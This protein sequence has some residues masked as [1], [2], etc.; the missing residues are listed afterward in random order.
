M[1][2][3]VASRFK[4][5]QDSSVL[6]KAERFA[7]F[8][9]PSLMAKRVQGTA[10]VFEGD[11]Q[12]VGALLVNNLT[13]KLGTALFP[14][15]RPFFKVTLSE[16]LLRQA[17]TDVASIRTGAAELE[18][19]STVQLFKNASL[20]KLHRAIS[21]AIVTGNF[22][23]YRDQVKQRFLVWNLNSYTVK[24]N[25]YGDVDEIILKQDMK[26]KDLE[27]KLQQEYLAKHFQKKPDDNVEYY[28]EIVYDRTGDVPIAF[29]AQSVDD[30]SVGDVAEYPEHICPYVAVAWNLAQGEHY[31]RGYVEDYSSD[32]HYL[33]VLSE[34]LA[35]YE[36]ESLSMLNLVDEAAGGVIDDYS[37]A[38]TGQFVPGKVGSITTYDRGDYNKIG[39][40]SA[41]LEEVK[42]RL[43]RAFMYTGHQRDAERVT[44]EE[45]RTLAQE[46]ENLLG[47]AYSVLA[48]GLQAPL[49]YLCMYEVA[50]E[51]DIA[52]LTYGVLSRNYHPE[53]LTGI[54]ALTQAAETQNLIRATQELV[55][56][57]PALMEFTNRF[58]NDK[59]IEMVFANNA[60][61]IESISKTPEQLEQEAEAEQQ[62][63]EA[64]TAAIAAGIE[65]GAMQ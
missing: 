25:A 57:I 59:I 10:Q 16:E 1:K 12:S 4:K 36:I 42:Q 45:V 9:L 33:S 40:I 65:D 34:E 18:R 43:S 24:R 37:E 20:A 3:D 27:P 22:L 64:E 52:A 47:G 55:Q 44:A 19:L 26:F 6:R 48:E 28:T 53:I 29:I 17:G 14:A 23:L 21:L 11:F 61:P 38:T 46:A 56:I 58:D 15:G 50:Q 5:A 2:N 41:R 62:Q 51:S 63:A 31:G 13:A 32:F 54:P 60:I 8:T 35:L 7:R 49:A 39:T 30:V